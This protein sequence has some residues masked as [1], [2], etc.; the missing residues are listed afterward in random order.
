[1]QQYEESYDIRQQLPLGPKH[2][3]V[4][5]SLSN[6]A[7]LLRQQVRCKASVCY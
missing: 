6:M 5:E 2:P 4:A 3:D 1:M 7:G